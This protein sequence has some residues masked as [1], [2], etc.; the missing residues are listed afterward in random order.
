VTVVHNGGQILARED[1]DVAVALQKALEAEGVRFVLNART[2][3]VAQQHR[4][5]ALTVQVGSGSETVTGSHLL[6]AT[7]CRPNADDLGLETTGV[8]TDAHGFIRVNSR[9]ETGVSGIWA[10]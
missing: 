5:V 2:T 4:Q 6:V 9:L 1:A 3:R 7:G 8:Q 10:L